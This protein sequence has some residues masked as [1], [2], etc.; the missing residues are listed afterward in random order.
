M[1]YIKA[2]PLPLPIEELWGV[3]GLYGSVE[4]LRHWWKYGLM[5]L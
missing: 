5:N 3:L 2:L 4:E 1:R